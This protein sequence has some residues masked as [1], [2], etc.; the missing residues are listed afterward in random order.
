MN[1]KDVRIHD[2][3]YLEWPL[4]EDD[5]FITLEP[6]RF[7]FMLDDEPISWIVPRG[8]KTD[9][10]SIPKIVPK[11]VAGKVGRHIPAAVI[12]DELC[13]SKPWT[14]TVAADIFNLIMEQMGVP[15]WRRSAMYRAVR[16]FGSQWG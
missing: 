11:W 16:H 10:A 14:S 8:T 3:I 9:L 13:L 15:A 2:P 6:I 7:S 5:Q 1:V 12:H 4:G